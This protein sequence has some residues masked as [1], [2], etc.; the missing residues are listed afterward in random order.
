MAARLRR[1]LQDQRR[2]AMLPEDVTIALEGQ[3][4][5]RPVFDDVRKALADFRYQDAERLL[6]EQIDELLRRSGANVAQPLAEVL[7]WRGLVAAVDDRE[8]PAEQRRRAKQYFAAA[9]ALNAELVIDPSMT[10]PRVRLFMEEAKRQRPETGTL[11]LTVTLRRSGRRTGP[12]SEASEAR[13]GDDASEGAGAAQ[14]RRTP[15][16]GSRGDGAKD[17]DQGG[18]SPAGKEPK[19]AAA[20]SAATAELSIDGRPSAPFAE[21]LE[22]PVGLHL[23]RV[24]APKRAS[25]LRLVEITKAAPVRLQVELA[26]ETTQ[27]KVLRLVGETASVPEGRPRLA[28]ASRLGAVVGASQ[29]L[30]L[31]AFESQRAKIRLYDVKGKRLSQQFSFAQTDSSA[32]V[33][34]AVDRAFRMSGGDGLE[35]Q[36]YQRWQVWAGVGAVVAGG[37]ATAVIISATSEPRIRGL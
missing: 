23:L 27:D 17:D 16:R 8:K 19:E 25:V 14:A 3:P 7:G 35:P 1:L 30:M 9:F 33:A 28:A 2:L 37:I 24:T 32:A 11:A 15:A 34:A 4:P 31:E 21:S 26:P 18:A 36:W 20:A 10:S 13:E 6:G 5:P 29:L 12:A 22:L